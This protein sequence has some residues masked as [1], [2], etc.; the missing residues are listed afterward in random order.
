MRSHTDSRLPSRCVTDLV[1]GI[2]D[3]LILQTEGEDGGISS[4]SR[5]FWCGL[6]MAVG[7]YWPW[8]HNREDVTSKA[9][10]PPVRGW[11]VA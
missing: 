2:G 7:C 8:G 4:H 10:A 11:G 5:R 3:L 1:W 9:R 6:R